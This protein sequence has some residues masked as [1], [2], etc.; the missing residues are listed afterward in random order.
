[1][2]MPGAETKQVA[3]ILDFPPSSFPLHPLPTLQCSGRGTQTGITGLSDHLKEINDLKGGKL[4][5][6]KGA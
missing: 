3:D 6:S 5:L 4:P 1:M 2:L